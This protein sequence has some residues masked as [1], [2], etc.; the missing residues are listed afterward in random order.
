[1]ATPTPTMDLTAM[2]TELDSQRSQAFFSLVRTGH[3]NPSIAQ[4]LASI[5]R[6]VLTGNSFI[7]QQ[8]ANHGIDTMWLYLIY[9][10][11]AFVALSGA[12]MG[13]NFGARVLGMVKYV[14]L[15]PVLG[16]PLGVVLQR[17]SW[18]EIKEFVLGDGE[19]G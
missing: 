1:M 19:S 17:R 3:L 12:E 7:R 6:A 14:F 16:I 2:E 10:A 13:L 5:Y 18:G 8:A 4:A 9:S 11:T 15:V